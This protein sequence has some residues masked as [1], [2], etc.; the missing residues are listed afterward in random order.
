MTILTLSLLAVSCI[1]DGYDLS[2]IDTDDLGIGDENSVFTCPLITLRA[3]V[4]DVTNDQDDLD[5]VLAEANVWL[6]NRLP[7]RIRRHCRC[8]GL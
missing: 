2:D 8:C 5:R 1:D 4:S 6:P 3:S 7:G